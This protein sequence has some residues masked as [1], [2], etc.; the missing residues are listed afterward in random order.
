MGPDHPLRLE[1]LTERAAIL[2]TAYTR[3]SDN[4]YLISAITEYES[5]LVEEPNN[6]SVLNNLA[7]MLVESNRKL[8]EALEYAERAHNLVPNE[9]GVSET[10]A[11]VLYKNGKYPEAAGA[12]QA[13]LQQYEQQRMSAP[14]EAYEHLGMIKEKLGARDEALAA[15]RQALKIGE[16]SLPQTVKEQINSA[17]ER[18]SRPGGSSADSK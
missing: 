17:I 9:S 10:Y 6:I 15:Y 3:T 18:L 2:A 4:S 7:Y 14:P 1:Y 16:S 12:I 11:Y 13:A 5:L 8:P